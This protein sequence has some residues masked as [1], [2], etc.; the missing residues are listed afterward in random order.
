MNTVQVKIESIDAEGKGIARVDGKAI[1]VKDVLPQEEAI[2]EIYKDKPKFGLGRLVELL[3]ASPDRVTPKCPNVG[4]CG[5]CSLQHLSFEA[6]IASKQQVLIDNLKHIGKVTPE[7]I[8]PPIVG[9]PWEYRSRAKFSV[10][11]DAEKNIALVGFLEKGSTAVADMQE[12]LIIPKHISDLIPGLRALIVRLSIRA[13][14]PK[15]EVSVGEKVSVL[16]FSAQQTLSKVDQKLL[17]DFATQHSTEAHPLQIWIQPKNSNTC[18]PLTP[19]EAPS[20]SYSLAEFNLEIPYFPAEFIQVNPLINQQMVDLAVNLL[21][22][23]ENDEVLDFFCG[24]GNF[25]MPIATQVKQVLGI[26]GNPQLVTRAQE[27]AVLNQLDHKISY[28]TADLYAI[29]SNWLTK[30]GK[31][32]KWLIDPPRIGAM[33]LMNSITS[34][35]APSKIVYV[36]C[37]P[38]T[39]ARDANILVNQHGYTLKNVGI[40]N[41]FPH[42]SHVES[43]AEFVK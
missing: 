24:I 42:T 27:N 20:L 35:S 14:L 18:Y 36:S 21:D 40:I 15:I 43:I 9:T 7:N 3:K 26:E 30:I 31:R 6:Q 33:E 19:L 12:C 22:L 16:M 37:N 13:K 10:Q 34:E 41:M 8:L 17:A 23:D 25:T 38:S 32:N 11:Y 1:F 28:L 39:F 29:D 5:G 2:I 4:T